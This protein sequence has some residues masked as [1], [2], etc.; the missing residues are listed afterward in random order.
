MTNIPDANSRS[1]TKCTPMGGDTTTAEFIEEKLEGLRLDY[2]FYSYNKVSGAK[3]FV[4]GSNDII[5]PDYLPSQPVAS[6]TLTIFSNTWL[7][8]NDIEMG[9]GNKA[10]AYDYMEFKDEKEAKHVMALTAILPVA[11]LIF[12]ILVWI[13]RRHA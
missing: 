3:L 5:N 6:T 4:L 13:K 11:I 10:T 9:I 12:G 2:G 8:D 7:Y 1:T